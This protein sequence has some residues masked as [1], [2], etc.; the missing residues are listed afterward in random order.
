MH[1]KLNYLEDSFYYSLE[2]C[3]S[4]TGTW[5]QILSMEDG[6]KITENENIKFI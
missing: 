1:C 2:D 3:D 4:K 6:Y 5:I